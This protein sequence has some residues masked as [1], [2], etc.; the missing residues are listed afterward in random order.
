MATSPCLCDCRNALF[1]LFARRS[2]HSGLGLGARGG[3]E[4]EAQPVLRERPNQRHR[5]IYFYVAANYLTCDR[6]LARAVFAIPQRIVKIIIAAVTRESYTRHTR[7]TYR[8]APAR[9]TLFPPIALQ[10][11][12]S[13]IHVYAQATG[14]RFHSSY[15]ELAHRRSRKCGRASDQPSIFPLSLSYPKLDRCTLSLPAIRIGVCVHSAHHGCWSNP[16][17]S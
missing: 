3:A 4:V 14:H 16:K 15:S 17:P 6:S 7:R 13:Y 9:S 8:F 1:F 2:P 11:L 5:A 12:P 10:A